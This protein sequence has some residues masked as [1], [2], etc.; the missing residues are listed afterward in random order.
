MNSWIE[1]QLKKDISQPSLLVCEIYNKWILREPWERIA[2]NYGDWC[3]MNSWT[4]DCGELQWRIQIHHN[5]SSFQRKRDVVNVIPGCQISSH[6]ADLL[7]KDLEAPNNDVLLVASSPLSNLIPHQPLHHH[8][9]KWQ[10]VDCL[11]NVSKHTQGGKMCYLSIQ[12]VP[13]TYSCS[14][15]CIL[16]R[17]WSTSTM[18]GWQESNLKVPEN[19]YMISLTHQLLWASTNRKNLKLVFFPC[20]NYRK[21]VEPT[22]HSKRRQDCPT[23]NTPCPSLPNKWRKY[24][25][26][27]NSAHPILKR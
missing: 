16:T 24:D 21:A 15:S 13:Q 26:Q 11:A 6:G 3:I 18:P 25:L 2:K 7:F 10:Q 12:P 23:L 22:T 27:S 5:P 20:C 9:Q 4:F 17:S 14:G 8:W 19:T 1:T